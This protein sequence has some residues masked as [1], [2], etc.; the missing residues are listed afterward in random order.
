MKKLFYKRRFPYSKHTVIALIFLIGLF[1]IFSPLQS[2][3]A[4]TEA[5]KIGDRGI[6][7]D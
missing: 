6:R 1:S 5:E 7:R 3:C 4:T 2:F